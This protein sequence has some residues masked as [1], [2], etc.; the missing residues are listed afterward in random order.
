MTINDNKKLNKSTVETGKHRFAS[1][2]SEADGLLGSL[3][4]E[5]FSASAICEL[6]PAF[7][8]TFN[9][10]S[11]VMA[12]DEFWTERYEASQL[13]KEPELTYYPL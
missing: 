2:G 6:L 13:R 12:V 3:L 5:S 9:M 10:A 11:A 4:M 7:F 1:T 8:Q